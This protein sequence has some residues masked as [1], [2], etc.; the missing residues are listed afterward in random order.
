[1]TS[2]FCRLAA[3]CALGLSLVA[4]AA[5]NDSASTG[6][7]RVISAQT[8]G[9]FQSY[10]R[11]IGPGNPGAFAVSE[12]GNSAHYFY[13]QEVRCMSGGSYRRGAVENCQKAAKQDCYTFASGRD[14][15]VSY[16]VQE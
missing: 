8:W 2:T 5:P 4:C 14:I 1:M 16:K 9:W 3:I 11:D 10:L 6:G 7:T 15:L 12:D 13:C